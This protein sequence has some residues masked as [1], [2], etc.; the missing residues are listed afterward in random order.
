MSS[1]K[2]PS[3]SLGDFCGA[4]LGISH[5]HDKTGLVKPPPPSEQEAL[6]V[7]ELTRSAEEREKTANIARMAANARKPSPRSGV[8]LERGKF[9]KRKREEWVA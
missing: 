5:R 3:S 8:G 2:V 6:V 7:K 1:S 4:Q 9:T